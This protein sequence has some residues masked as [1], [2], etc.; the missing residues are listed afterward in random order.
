MTIKDIRENLELTQV[1]FAQ[2][3]GTTQIS[4]SRWEAGIVRPGIEYLRKIAALGGCAIEDITPTVRRL[5]MRD[6]LTREA[7]ESLTAE[8]RRYILKVE[9]AKEYSGWRR[10]P[11][12][13]SKLVERVPDEWWD[14][15]NAEH[16][17]EVMAL[18]KAA[19][20]DGIAYGR[21]R[22]E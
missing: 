19:Y 17:G 1:E 14:K 16:I 20:D 11:T 3:L 7:Y 9:Q 22:E 10:Y 2:K 6:A 15:Y 13:M 8:E 5:K 18:L 4:V 21:A 12:T